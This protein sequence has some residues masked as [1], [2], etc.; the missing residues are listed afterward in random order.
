MFSSN[1]YEYIQSL[2]GT[3]QKQGYNYYLCH[4]ISDNSYSDYDICIYFS[5]DKIEAVTDNYFEVKNGIQIYIDSSQKSSYGNSNINDNVVSSSYNN[6]VSVDKAEFVYTNADLIE[7]YTIESMAIN[8]DLSVNS[9]YSELNYVIVILIGFW[10]L[11]SFIR[12]LFRN[13]REIGFE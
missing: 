2:V 9:N 5:K 3:Y 13:R 4:T 7:G 11:Y 8:P 6:F 10:F 1:E 12:D